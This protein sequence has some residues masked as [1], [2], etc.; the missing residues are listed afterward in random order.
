MNPLCGIKVFREQ[1]GSA[2]DIVE[3]K[4]EAKE[5]GQS[6]KYDLFD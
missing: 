3:K 5:L 1:L 4:R 2:M 6:H